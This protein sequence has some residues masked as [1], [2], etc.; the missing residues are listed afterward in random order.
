VG[1]SGAAA[2]TSQYLAKPDRAKDFHLLARAIIRTARS[3]EREVFG[4]Y[5]VIGRAALSKRCR[6]RRDAV[7][8]RS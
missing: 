1:Y 5:Y 6:F 7:S 2:I 8:P 3:D 4:E